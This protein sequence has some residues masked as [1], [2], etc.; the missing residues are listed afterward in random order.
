LPNGK[1]PPVFPI[2][3]KLLLNV[4]PLNDARTPRADFF[5]ILLENE[6]AVRHMADGLPESPTMA[7]IRG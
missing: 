7:P 4:K 1:T 3:E 5:S 2:S 6:Q